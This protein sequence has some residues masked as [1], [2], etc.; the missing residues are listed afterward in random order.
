MEVPGQRVDDIKAKEPKEL[1]VIRGATHMDGY[2]KPQPV[3]P[4]VAK[5]TAFFSLHLSPARGSR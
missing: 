2:D 3:T 5:L 1:F 4:A